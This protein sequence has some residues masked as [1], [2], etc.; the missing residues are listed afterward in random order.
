LSNASPIAVTI[1][2]NADVAFEI[3]ARID[4]IQ[5]GAGKVT[6]SGAGV[7]INSKSSAKSIAGTNVAV[8]LIKEATDTWYLIGDLLA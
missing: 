5:K 1:P 2:I 3:G 7:T 6:F 4:L 8:T